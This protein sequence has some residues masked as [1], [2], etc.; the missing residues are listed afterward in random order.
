M[1]LKTLISVVLQCFALQLKTMLALQ[2][3]LIQ[4]IMLLFWMNYQQMVKQALKLVNVW[5][6]KTPRRRKIFGPRNWRLPGGSPGRHA[7]VTGSGPWR[8]PR[9]RPGSG[10]RMSG[11]LDIWLPPRGHI[12]R[13]DGGLAPWVSP[14]V[15]GPEGSGH[16]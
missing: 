9:R 1:R 12:P 2:L 4:L 14:Q 15:A 7:P 11:M 6:L 5:Q 8:T 16:S 13:R 10:G 3:L